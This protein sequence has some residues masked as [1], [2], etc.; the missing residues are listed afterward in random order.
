[1][2]SSHR[3]ERL[4]SLC[5]NINVSRP[6]EQSQLSDE[7]LSRENFIE[8]GTADLVSARADSCDLCTFIAGKIEEYEKKVS[9]RWRKLEI[10]GYALEWQSYGSRLEKTDLPNVTRHRLDI[11]L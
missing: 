1:M 5:Q 7:E 9:D 4:C 8:L 11:I 6:E 2:A 10:S 3:N